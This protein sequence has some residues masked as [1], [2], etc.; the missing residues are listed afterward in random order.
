MSVRKSDDFIADIERQSAISWFAGMNA[1]S[2]E[3]PLTK[4]SRIPEPDDIGAG[5]LII[6][7]ALI[8][9]FSPRRRRIV[10][11]RLANRTLL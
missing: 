11:R 1:P 4:R 6:T 3:A 9:A 2:A 7:L 10:V 5:V 8:P